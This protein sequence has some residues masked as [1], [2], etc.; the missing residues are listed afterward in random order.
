[1]LKA[2]CDVN[3][4]RLIVHNMGIVDMAASP[5]QLQQAGGW[6]AGGGGGLVQLRSSHFWRPL[7]APGKGLGMP[8]PGH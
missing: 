7:A 5:Q 8:A 3:D 2:K 6:A 4:R 1:M